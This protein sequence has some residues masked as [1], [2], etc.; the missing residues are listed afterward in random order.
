ME[1]HDMI[2]LELLNCQ[3]KGK[4]YKPCEVLCLNNS[5]FNGNHELSLEN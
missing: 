5:H 1:N 4:N 2:M 3:T